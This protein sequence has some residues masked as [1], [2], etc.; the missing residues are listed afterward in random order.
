M[1]SWSTVYAPDDGRTVGA[2]WKISDS[3]LEWAIKMAYHETTKLDE[4]EA[5]LWTVVN[6][7]VGPPRSWD[8][9]LAYGQDGESFSHFMMRFSQPINPAQIGRV[10][11]YDRRATVVVNWRG[12]VID[13]PE[14][15][16]G[17]AGSDACALARA[18]AR[19][20]R[21]ENNLKR[22]LSW[23]EEHA[24]ETVDLV[25]R[26]FQGQVPNKGFPGWTD[27]AAGF[28]RADPDAVAVTSSGFDNAFYRENWAK[29]WTTE[30]VKIVPPGGGA[31]GKPV[32]RAGFSALMGFVMAGLM[33]GLVTAAG[34]GLGGR[35]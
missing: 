22:P 16:D 11:P 12:E 20:L 8:K 34:G 23:Y 7:W 6:R 13:E 2:V 29:D 10:L 9:R 25:R 31:G 33:I 14:C 15:L 24:P 3:D 1:A 26:F 4:Q 27:F 17:G 30:S 35:R 21:I 32:F 28:V 19:W 5:V 18:S